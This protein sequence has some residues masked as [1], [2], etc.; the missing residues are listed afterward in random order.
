MASRKRPADDIDDYSILDHSENEAT[1]L[2]GVV[3]N[4]SPVKRGKKANYF[5]GELT[6]GTCRIRFIGFKAEQHKQ[7]QEL[8]K[9]DSSIE[10]KDCQI[11]MSRQGHCMEALLKGASKITSSPKSFNLDNDR[12]GKPMSI[13]KAQKLPEYTRVTVV[14]KVLPISGN[15]KQE[16]ARGISGR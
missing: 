7:L 3:R 8:S 12:D 6:D 1:N 11:K 2:H 9:G 4:L 14:V 10:I 16:E 5:D 15:R 13:E